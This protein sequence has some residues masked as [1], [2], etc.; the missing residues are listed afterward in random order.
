MILDANGRPVSSP[1]HARTLRQA[2]RREER[3]ATKKLEQMARPLDAGEVARFKK[4]AGMI[5]DENHL[6]AILAN[7]P[8]ERRSEIRKMIVP[9]VKF[10]TMEAA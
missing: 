10:K 4:L 2:R 1:L 5:V 8:P 3:L 9:H 6:D 7:V